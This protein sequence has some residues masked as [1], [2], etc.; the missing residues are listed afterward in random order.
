MDIPKSVLICEVG[1][2][3]GLQN[4]KPISTEAKIKFIDLLTASGV[5]VVELTSFVHPKLVPSMADAEAVISGVRAPQGVLF[6]GLALNPKGV[7]RAIK[8]GIAQV[9]VGVSA[10]DAHSQEN[11]HCDTRE[12]IASIGVM[13]EMAAQANLPIAGGIAVAFWCPY[14]GAVPMKRL[15][16]I[17][18][19]YQRMHMVEINLS[20]TAGMTNPKHVYETVVH[21]R[22]RFPDLKFGLHVHDTFGTGLANALAALQAGIDRFDASA[23]GLGGCPFIPH[24]T[25]NIA[26]EDLVYMFEGMGIDTGIDV[27]KLLDAAE[28]IRGSLGHDLF[29]HTFQAK[30]GGCALPAA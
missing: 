11:A 30:R 7:E 29:S 13:A 28:Y 23:G 5:K 14:E 19:E 8:S 6:R 20:D 25:G 9:K 15:E 1:P 3:D 17:C 21:L 26:T 10:T 24:A 4:E 2:R 22:S 27:D 12:A 16:E 18:A